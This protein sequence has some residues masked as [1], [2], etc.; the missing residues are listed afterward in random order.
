MENAPKSAYEIAMER[1]KAQDRAEG[2]E[3]VAL[4]DAQKAEIAEARRVAS[5]RLAE[6][7]I[8]L[9]DALA[10][11]YEP[12]ARAKLEEEFRTDRRRCEEDRDRAIER[13]RRG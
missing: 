8:R 11:T 5:A 2:V 13:I 7:E 9:R 10:R 4:S 6:L 1:L 3:E 12:D